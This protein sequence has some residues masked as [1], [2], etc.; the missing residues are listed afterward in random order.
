MG[1]CRKKK[2]EQLPIDAQIAAIEAIPNEK[3]P[4]DLYL[5]LRFSTGMLMSEVANSKT[6]NSFFQSVL[7]HTMRAAWWVADAVFSGDDKIANSIG[8]GIKES[9]DDMFI[10]TV[11]YRV[12]TQ[13]QE[14][15]TYYIYHIQVVKVGLKAA[16]NESCVHNLC[17]PLFVRKCVIDTCG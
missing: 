11:I 15:F 17:C 10:D 9:L 13:Q 6:Q 16:V 7:D 2:K 1:L 3:N 12:L 4:D 8:A 14:G 5:I